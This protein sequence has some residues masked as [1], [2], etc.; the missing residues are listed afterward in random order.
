MHNDDPFFLAI[1]NFAVFEKKHILMLIQLCDKYFKF[2]KNKTDKK[3][4]PVCFS[5][6]IMPIQVC[7]IKC[8]LRKKKNERKVLVKKSTHNTKQKQ[9]KKITTKKKKKNYTVNHEQ[10]QLEDWDFAIQTEL[11]ILSYRPDIVVKNYQRKIYLLID[12]SG[13]TD[14]NISVKEYNKTSK[15]I[16]LEIEIEKMWHLETTT[17]GQIKETDKP[18]EK[19]PEGRSQ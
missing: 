13:P 18:I 8:L 9:E 15:Y 11:K 19:I 17:M 1:D 7:V 16:D 5:V 6:Y 14:N 2:A 4:L 12:M 10:H 3:D